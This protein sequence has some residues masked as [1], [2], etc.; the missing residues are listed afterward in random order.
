MD[1]AIEREKSI[2]STEDHYIPGYFDI[3]IKPEEEKVI[4][5]ISTVEKKIKNKD[6]LDIIKKEERRQKKLISSSG[7]KDEFAKKLVLAA[8]QIYSIQG[9]NRCQNHYS[10]LS[11][12][13]RLGKGYNDSPYRSYFFNKEI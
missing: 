12:V 2:E 1:Y 11:L 3:D 9:I 8:E 4:T 13:Y 10:G 5:I 7:Y 6:G